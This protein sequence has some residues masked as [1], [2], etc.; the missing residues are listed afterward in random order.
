MSSDHLDGWAIGIR[1]GEVSRPTGE[2]SK[3]L[4]GEEESFDQSPNRGAVR[5]EDGGGE[6][7][8]ASGETM[9]LA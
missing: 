5:R 4:K 3:I 9:E 2:I 6:G 1:L 8:E 7:D